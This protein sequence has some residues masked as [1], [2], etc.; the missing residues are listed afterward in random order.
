MRLLSCA[1][2]YFATLQ[3]YLLSKSS[4]LLCLDTLSKKFLNVLVPLVDKIDIMMYDEKKIKFEKYDNYN[5]HQG[6]LKY[7]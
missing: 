4:V 2:L 5:D 7:P 3:K 6:V 1:S